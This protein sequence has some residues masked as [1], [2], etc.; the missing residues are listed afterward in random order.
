MGRSEGMDGSEDVEQAVAAELRLLDPAV[1]T[2]PDLAAQL[3]HPDFSEVGRSGRRWDRASILAAL[4][5]MAGSTGQD[6]VRVDGMSGRSLAPGVV[7]LTYATEAA[8]VR[9]WRSS[10]WV[11]D[12]GGA[13]RVLYHQGTP[14]EALR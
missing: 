1:R 6:R 14:A 10:L 12:E 3:L 5:T 8:G 13:W 7:H 9:A 11:R 4:P 2:S